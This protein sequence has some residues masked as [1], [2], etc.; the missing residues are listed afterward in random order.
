MTF[1][2]HFPTPALVRLWNGPEMK[3][4]FKLHHQ[5]LLPASTFH[6]SMWVLVTQAS[7][8]AEHDWVEGRQKDQWMLGTWEF[9]VG[10]HTVV[11]YLNLT[12]Q[13]TAYFANQTR[14]VS[15][16]TPITYVPYTSSGSS[17]RCR[18]ERVWLVRQSQK[19]V[20]KSRYS[21]LQTSMNWYRGH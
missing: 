1:Q 20:G 9:L 8:L 2:L 14:S 19:F 5:V 17:W 4:W 11:T 16:A 13:Q 6:W 10:V 21:S 15:M 3:V 18:T 7:I 12:I